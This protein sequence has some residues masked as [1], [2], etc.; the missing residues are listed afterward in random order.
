MKPRFVA[1]GVAV[2]L[3]V[4]GG[5][6]ARP[7]AQSAPSGIGGY[8]VLTLE[9]WDRMFWEVSNWG[10]W[11][12]DDQLGAVNLITPEKRKQ[13]AAL[14][15]TGRS[16][17]LE[18]QL[19]ET[20]DPDVHTPFQKFN[21]GNKLV[22]ETVH[23]GTFHSHVDAL[24]HFFYQGKA[25]NGYPRE[26]VE[27]DD[28]CHKL[29][30]DVWKDGF[31]T[32]GVLIDIPRLKGLPWLEPG[33]PVT[34]RDIEAWEEETG[35]EVLPGDA[36]FLRTGKWARRAALGPWKVGMAGPDA[37]WHWSV[38]PWFKARDVAIIADDGPNDVR[39]P[40][41]ERG[42]GLPIH[43]A[44]LVALGA[45]ILDGQDLEAVADLAEELGRWEFMVTGAPLNIKA[46]GGS[47]INVL[48][49]F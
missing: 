25:Y 32:R 37:G 39:P 4:A 44:A 21:H 38:I 45:V 29:G 20:A 34:L 3:L 24:C 9:A 27:D 10:R 36:V 42:V 5:L 1:C 28:G 12:P 14:V 8:P 22:W 40:G 18:H 6:V 2:A 31:I 41:V 35:I 33:T 11:G 13:A 46:G 43:S 23:G 47:S 7:S 17:S 49:T 19:I 30:I 26:E 15:R 48:A 16:V